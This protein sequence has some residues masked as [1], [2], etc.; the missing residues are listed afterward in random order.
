MQQ[1]IGRG[2]RVIDGATI[3]IATVLGVTWAFPAA[4]DIAAW[5]IERVHAQST[6]TAPAFQ[7]D[8]LWPKPLPN[9][10]ILGSVTGVA[11]DTQDHIWIVHRGA[12]SLTARTENG[13]GTNPPTAELC[14][15]PAP[16]VLEFDPSGTLVSS[17]GGPGEGYDWPESPGGIAIDAKGMV[18]IAAAG[19]PEA[20]TA[21]GRGATGGPG[22][23]G[24][25]GRAATTPA[26]PPRPID[27]HVLQFTRAGKFV[28]QIGKPGVT[29]GPDSRTSLNRPADVEIDAGANEIYVADGHGHRRV[30]VFDAAT[31]AYKRQ[32]AAY[33]LAPDATDPGPYDPAAPPAKQFRTVSCVTIAKDGMVYVCDRQNNRVQVFSKDGKFVKETIVSKTTL[34]NGAVWDIALSSDAGQRHL[35]I[36]D[37]TDQKIV[38]L[39]RNTLTPVGEFGGG[40]R[41]PGYF[42]G[43]GSLGVDS[44]GNVYTGETFEGKR[45]QKFAPRR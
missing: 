27:A 23:T 5:S 9:G 16:P 2:M 33:G 8:P 21:R 24:G 41:W 15:R 36:A 37:G 10:W 17:W 12:A 34:G 42:Y 1:C 32:W 40:G 22:G 39:Q 25:A 30:V 13:L 28:R 31:G 3:A 26:P 29:Q 35:F 44:R 43:V 38:V 11:V 45:V 7:V 20:V 18:W 6:P 19:F 4:V 14:C